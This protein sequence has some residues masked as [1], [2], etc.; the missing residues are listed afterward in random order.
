MKFG[1]DLQNW[2]TLEDL[3][4][5]PLKNKGAELWVFGSRARGD[6]RQFSDIDILVRF[7]PGCQVM[8]GELFRIKDDLIESNLPIKVD[9]V[10]E[11]ELAETYRSQILKEMVQI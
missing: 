11:H 4:I 3:L 1:L 8:D 5:N 10:L 9:L 2:K 7:K 6:H